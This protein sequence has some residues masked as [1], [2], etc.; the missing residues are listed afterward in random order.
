YRLFAYI[1]FFVLFMFLILKGKPYYTLG[2]YVMMFAFGGYC[3]G[4]YFTGKRIWIKHTILIF[5][6]LAVA[7]T[8]PFGLPILP[9][10]QMEKFCT[11]Y[12]D[13]ITSEP[14]RGE[15]NVFYPLP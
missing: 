4:K 15:A 10:K 2:V 6:I 5:T 9:Q 13:Y 7:T 11:F 1:F 12:S 3:M 14:M 8:L